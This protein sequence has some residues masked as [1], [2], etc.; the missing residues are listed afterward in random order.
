MVEIEFKEREKVEK[1]YNEI[2]NMILTR[3]DNQSF[4]YE[5]KQHHL[6]EESECPGISKDYYNESGS[7]EFKN[8]DG[9]LIKLEIERW[10][11][12]RHNGYSGLN[13]NPCLRAVIYVI[14]NDN[15]NIV[16]QLDVQSGTL[17][18]KAEVSSL[19]IPN[20]LLQE[21]SLGISCNMEEK[22]EM[23]E[24]EIKI[25]ELEEKR[26]LFDEI[27]NLYK[28]LKCIEQ[29]KENILKQCKND[30]EEMTKK[31][32]ESYKNKIEL[33]NTEND[34][35]KVKLN[36][37]E[38]LLKKYST[39]NIDIIGKAFQELISLMENNNYLY[40]QVTY[41]QNEKIHGPI[42]SWDESIPTTI[43]I[44]AKE[45]NLI[46]NFEKGIKELIRSDSAI[47]LSDNNTSKVSFY[48][49]NNGQITCNVD[50]GRFSYIKQFID[51]IVQYRFQNRMIDFN[52]KD[53]LLFMKK[54]IM[55]HEDI[56]IKNYS[57]TIKEKV[58]NLKLN[59]E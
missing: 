28:K 37:F 26:I 35:I 42:D 31:I 38:E 20:D 56:I 44:V 16:W 43:N 25:D 21:K 55:E 32:N 51:S 48:G 2:K 11:N 8:S 33:N 52:E 6:Y 27:I 22:E 47:I 10:H 41:N 3:K 1:L 34:S 29:E 18:Y 5:K 53:I 23:V 13:G 46:N 54:F 58:L 9:K 39:F 45:D 24:E 4:D 49:L 17:F 57:A 40:K 7:V 14:E 50:F 15:K 30:I 19:D 36:E 12:H 59:K